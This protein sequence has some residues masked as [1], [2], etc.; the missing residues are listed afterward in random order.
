MCS[1][2]TDNLLVDRMVCQDSR[3]RR[4]N[5]S[6]AWIDV[7]KAFDSVSHKWLLEMMLLHTF[8]ELGH[9]DSNYNKEWNG[10]I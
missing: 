8:P 10:N 2:T 9:E 6:M 1:G 3:N 5:A 4:K 7:R